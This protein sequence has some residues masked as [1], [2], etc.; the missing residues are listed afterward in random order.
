MTS[1]SSGGHA[2]GGVLG[3]NTGYGDA[4]IAVRNTI[5]AKNEAVGGDP[6]VGGAFVS[7]GHNLIGVLTANATGFDGSDLSGTTATPLD[8]LLLPLRHNGGPTMTHAL[9]KHSPAINAGDNSGAPATD[10]RGKPR[11]VDG[12]IDIGAYERRAK[13]GGNDDDDDFWKSWHDCSA[14]DDD[15]VDILASDDRPHGHGKVELRRRH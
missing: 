4:N 14:V 8:P 15:L 12:T 2:S 10:Q 5:I 3:A 1:A 7:L 13:S 6:D 11:I 9:A